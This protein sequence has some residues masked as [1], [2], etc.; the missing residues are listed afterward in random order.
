MSANDFGYLFAA[1]GLRI[2]SAAAAAAVLTVFL[3]LAAAEIRSWWHRSDST[4]RRRA[5]RRTLASDLRAIRAWV[6]T[7][8][9]A[10]RRADAALEQHLTACLDEKT[11]D[12]TGATR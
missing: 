2:A 7:H 11:R 6:S 12:L 3:L 1:A 5:P 9:T 10:R 4:G 8:L